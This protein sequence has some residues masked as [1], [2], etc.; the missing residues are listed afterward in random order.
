MEMEDALIGIGNELRDLNK[1]VE[2]LTKAVDKLVDET[3]SE[4][5][6]TS[7]NTMKSRITEAL[8]KMTKAIEGFPKKQ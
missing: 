2:K 5:S 6:N 3:K 1:N 4:N 8:E 7:K